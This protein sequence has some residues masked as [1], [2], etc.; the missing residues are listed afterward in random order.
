MPETIELEK[1]TEKIEISFEFI[2]EHFKEV[3]K[4]QK[5]DRL[6]F[7][8]CALLS[9]ISI[10]IFLAWIVLMG[11]MPVVGM[12]MVLAVLPFVLV[13]PRMILFV[14]KKISTHIN[15]R[16]HEDNTIHFSD[17]KEKPPHTSLVL[18]KVQENNTEYIAFT[19]EGEGHIETETLKV[20]ESIFSSITKELS[21]L[22][23]KELEL[24]KYSS[25]G[26]KHKLILIQEK[27]KKYEKI[28][29]Y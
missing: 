15:F 29:H 13:P 19:L 10:L 28:F 20:A 7:A 5:K 4:N 8:A 25:S 1:N 23:D 27:I 9:A 26:D 14:S 3:E 6:Q 2:E 22:R 11:M 18:S 16:F 12:M 17:S 24:R 21:I